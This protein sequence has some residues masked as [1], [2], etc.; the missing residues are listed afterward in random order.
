MA[1]RFGAF[2][3]DDPGKEYVYGPTDTGKG[4]GSI[5]TGSK[6]Q[7]S[8]APKEKTRDSGQS[9]RDKKHDKEIYAQMKKDDDFMNEPNQVRGT[10]SGAYDGIDQPESVDRKPE[11]L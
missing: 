8:S 1:G 7:P 4:G 10:E 3:K 2:Y 11:E 9:R 5:S 6:G